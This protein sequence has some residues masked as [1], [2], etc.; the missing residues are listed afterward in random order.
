MKIHLALALEIVLTQEPV[1]TI[2]NVQIR[3]TLR[4]I[5][6][7]QTEEPLPAPENPKPVNKTVLETVLRGTS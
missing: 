2:I 4:A 1:P 3:E 7:F 6:N 5:M